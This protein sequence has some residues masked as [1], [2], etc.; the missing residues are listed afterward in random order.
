MGPPPPRW[1]EPPSVEEEK[2]ELSDYVAFLKDE[3]EAVQAHIAQLK[4][5]S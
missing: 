4:E 5:K 1:W 2:E 3:L